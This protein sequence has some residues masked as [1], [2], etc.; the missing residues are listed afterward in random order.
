MKLQ[1]GSVD[2]NGSLA[3]VSQQAWIFNGTVRENILMGSK[4]EESWYK[5]VVE[6]CALT[7]DFK[8]CDKKIYLMIL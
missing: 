6:A 1:S 4:F 2:V 7:S 5:E 3:L 8:V